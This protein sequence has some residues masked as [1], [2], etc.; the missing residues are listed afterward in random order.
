M[1]EIRKATEADKP[2]IWKI[3]K[4]V[5]ATGD[6]YTF[7]PDSPEEEMLAFWMSPEKWT[8]VAV[9]NEAPESAEN[10]SGDSPDLNGKIVGT[11]FLKANQPGLGAHVG[12]AGYMVA[13]EAKGKRVGRRMAEFSIEES[14]R[15]GFHSIQ[16]NFVV[17]SNAV[18][19]KLWQDV[20]FRIIGEIPEAFNHARD[21]LTNAYIMYRKL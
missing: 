9:W 11:F 18:A 16:F 19:V 6:T 15:L 1:L 21:G 2:E 13:P 14:R 17:K 10:T 12:N 5:I 8:Y 20:G 7:A 4:A 3:I